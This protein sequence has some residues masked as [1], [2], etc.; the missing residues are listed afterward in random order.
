[1]RFS[2]L[3]FMT[4]LVSSCHAFCPTTLRSFR[5]PFQPCMAKGLNRARNKQA[6]ILKKME[7]AKKQNKEGTSSTSD[8]NEQDQDAIH[9]QQQEQEYDRLLFAEL[10]AKSQP[11]A[12]EK[13]FTDLSAD[14]TRTSNKSKVKAKQV[15]RKKKSLKQQSNVEQVEKDVPLQQGDIAKRRHFE[16]LVELSTSKPLGA[17][18]A[19]QLVPW[20]PPYLS[21]YLVVICDA[22]RQSGDLRQAL[23]YLTSNLSSDVISQ[24]IVI[25]ADINEETAR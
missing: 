24:V 15:K 14:I 25:S 11:I 6:E 21:D 23:Q 19:A 16:S 10:L 3:L 2:C 18:A 4:L 17:A 22:R 8:D 20:V 7:L 5:A 12:S 13:T 1:M 9:R